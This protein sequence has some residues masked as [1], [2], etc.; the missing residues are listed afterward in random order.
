V[1]NK[2]V[3]KILRS[4]T[5]KSNFNVVHRQSCVCIQFHELE[6][7][8]RE[9]KDLAR[10]G[11]NNLW[12]HYGCNSNDL[13]EIIQ[14][15]KKSFV[16]LA[17]RTEKS[18]SFLCSR[19]QNKSKEI[20]RHLAPYLQTSLIQLFFVRTSFFWAE[21]EPEP[22]FLTFLAIWAWNVLNNDLYKFNC[23]VFR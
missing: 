11:I 18:I 10:Y 23:I 4:K 12:I 19:R 20:K 14:A 7:F 21:A 8:C 16:C 2:N 17:M 6:L 22:N 5:L 3:W 13:E 15:L 9:I 1:L